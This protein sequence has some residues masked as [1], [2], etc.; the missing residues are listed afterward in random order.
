MNTIVALSIGQTFILMLLVALVGTDLVI[1]FSIWRH[2]TSYIEKNNRISMVTL[3]ETFDPESLCPFCQVIRLPQ[4]R[5]CNICNRCIDRYDHHC[6]WINNCVGRTNHSRFYVHLILIV[7]YCVGSLLNAI[8]KLAKNSDDVQTTGVFKERNYVFPE[9]LITVCI[10]SLLVF[11][12]VFGVLVFALFIY[13]TQNL[14]KGVTSTERTRR[15]RL[16]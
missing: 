4:S 2:N 14:M 5:H 13:Q 16:N 8:L 15:L 10:I 11:G 3:L 1:F 9:S 6:P 12:L 7:A